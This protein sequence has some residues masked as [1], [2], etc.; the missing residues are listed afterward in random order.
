[1]TYFRISTTDYG[2]RIVCARDADEAL[3]VSS[4]RLRRERSA[5]LIVTLD[6]VSVSPAPGGL[7]VDDVRALMRG[8]SGR[9]S[10]H[11]EYDRARYHVWLDE[12]RVPVDDAL[13][14]NPPLEHSAP[15]DPAYFQTRTLSRTAILGRKIYGAMRLIADEQDLFAQA[16][17]AEALKEQRE[18]EAAEIER[19]LRL[20]RDAG[21]ELFAALAELVNLLDDGRSP[22]R[23]L[24]ARNKAAI[25]LQI[26]EHGRQPETVG[27][28]GAA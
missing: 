14:K 25:A 4:E 18:R 15:Q 1:M 9:Y 7:V 13:Y 17:Q 24:M 26:A 28:G 16:L 6:P 19:K 20:Q 11:C 21:P 23:I 10:L 27:M 3:F 12:R 2:V 5:A 22:M 8:T